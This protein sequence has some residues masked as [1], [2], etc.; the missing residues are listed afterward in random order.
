MQQRL[1]EAWRRRP[2]LIVG[3]AIGAVAL[4]SLGAFALN[5]GKGVSP[6]AA[7]PALD[8]AVVAPVEPEIQPGERMEVG[9]LVDEFDANAIPKPVSADEADYA[10]EDYYLEQPAYTD[11]APPPRVRRYASDGYG[12]DQYPRERYSS[13]GPPPDEWRTYEGRG[14]RMGLGFDG[15]RP[16]SG[17]ERE[18]RRPRGEPVRRYSSRPTGD[19]DA[20]FY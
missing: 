9:A 19:P 10:G 6:R 14:D 5:G 17:A 4:V 20:A 1:T 15:P 13:E 8:I 12:G 3:G 7:G 18:A 11:D 2:R 16:E